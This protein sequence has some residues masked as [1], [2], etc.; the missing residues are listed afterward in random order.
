MADPLPWNALTPSA[1]KH[2]SDIIELL[3][4]GYTGEL[5]LR[6]ADGGVK[7]LR[8]S[9][10]KATVALMVHTAREKRKLTGESGAP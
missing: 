4:A 3:A 10:G 6:C 1:R 9:G 5:T 8:A 7:D 2:V